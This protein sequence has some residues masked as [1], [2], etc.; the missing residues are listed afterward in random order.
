MDFLDKDNLYGNNYNAFS[1][2]EYTKELDFL[3][4]LINI[5]N[6]AIQQ[7]ESSDTW[8]FE[9]V[10]YSIAKTIVDYSKMAYDNILLG[11]FHAVNMINRS[12]LEN[13]VF[14]DIIIN[15]HKHELWKYYWIYSC[16]APILKSNKTPK[17][18]DLEMLQKIYE[19]LNISDDFYI[20]PKGRH[21]A[22]IE[23]QYGWTYKIN[24]DRKFTFKGICNLAKRPAEYLGFQMMSEYSHGTSFCLKLHSSV[25]ICDMMN[26]FINM[27]INLY[28]MITI[29]CWDLADE[30]FDEVAEELEYIFYRYVEHEEDLWE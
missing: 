29:Y 4:R 26:M 28:R 15:N 5:A 2:C 12:V 24:K 30:D 22:Y 9:G 16:A 7:K 23:E 1:L 8:S 10:C 14:L 25:F 13:G 20:M 3:K 6:N 11:H 18:S 27:Y 17:Q 19:E 21:R